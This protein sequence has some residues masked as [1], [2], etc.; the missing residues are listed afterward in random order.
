[1]VSPVL[2]EGFRDGHFLVSKAAA[3]QS[4]ENGLITNALGV[5]ALFVAGTVMSQRTLA[6]PVSV[7]TVGNV[8]NGVVSGLAL[9]AG[10]LL[11][12]YKFTARD[13]THFLVI[14]PDGRELADLT[15]GQPYSDGVALAVTAGNTAFAANDSF[16][17]NV[18]AG[19][20]IWVPY[21]GA[22]PAAGILFN[23]VYVPAGATKKVA[24]VRR[25]A[26]VNAGEVQ[27]DPSVI[28]AGNAASLQAQ[29]IAQ[30]EPRG[31]LFRPT[32]LL[33]A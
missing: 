33:V 32:G 13:G 15:V 9:A 19:D 23:Q 30:L 28:A 24:I 5:D 22:L 25:H 29:A 10:A 12:T 18:A 11:G 1:M 2:Y 21:T 26:E 20:L 14:G 31:I 8:G 7:N 27:W 6:T 4:M 17:V 3:T 16:S